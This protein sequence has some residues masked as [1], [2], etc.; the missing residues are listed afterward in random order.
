MVFLSATLPNSLEFAEWVASVHSSPCHV[1]STDYRPTPLVH[2]GFPSGT[3]KGVYLLVDDKG[4]W[5]AESWA[6]MVKEAGWKKKEEEEGGGG[7]STAVPPGGE[8]AKGGDKK[9]KENKKPRGPAIDEEVERLVH[10]IKAKDM[11]P[12]IVFSFSRAQC[13]LLARRLSKSITSSSKEAGGKRKRGARKGKEDVVQ[14]LDFT[15]QEEKAAITEVFNNAMQCLSVEDREL[16]CLTA[17]LPLLLRGVGV[18]HSGLL[19]ILKEV[20]EL[21]FQEQLIKCLFS[22]ETFAMGLNMPAKSVV[23]TSLRKFDGRESRY[24]TSGEYIQ[25]SGRA[26]R[27]GKDEKGFAIM[28]LEGEIRF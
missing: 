10:L 11:A 18:H 27:R 12:V 14:A 17:M 9:K 16:P 4:N 26:G 20:V 24:L 3:D 7:G 23:F 2:Y 19:P 8:A 22:T 13:E 5:R 15:N 25:M 28:L 21:L 6:A 1:V